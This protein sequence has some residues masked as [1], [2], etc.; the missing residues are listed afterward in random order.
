MSFEEFQPEESPVT[1]KDLSLLCDEY[2]KL[3]TVKSEAEDAVAV[4]SGRIKEIESKILTIMKDSGIPNFKTAT[5]TV[6]V[7][8]NKS[9]AQP[10]SMEEKMQFFDYLKEQG[11]FNEMVKVDSRTL[12]SWASKEIEAKEKDGI[13]GWTP[14]GLKPAKEYQS[15]SFRKK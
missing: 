14:P 11:I 7:K 12:S 9:I 2:A 8:T 1:L 4:I 6:S 3:K 10:S 13:F 15:L 5:A